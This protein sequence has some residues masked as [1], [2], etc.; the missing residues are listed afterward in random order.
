MHFVT[1]E[2]KG[3]QKIGILLQDKN[4]VIPLQEAEKFYLKSETLPATMQE[5]IEQGESAV[6]TT[7]KILSMLDDSFK[8]IA[9]AEVTI[10]APIPYPKKNI[11]CIGKNYVD[12]ALEV[13]KTKDVNLAVPKMPII[14]SKPPTSVVGTG[15]IVKQHKPFVEQI[16]YEAE[17]A[18][19]IGKTAS[20]VKK[21][22]VYD[23]V[24]G[25]SI[26]ND[27]TARDLQKN[28]VQW[29]MGKGPDTYAP[30]GPAIVHKS[31]IE[32]PHDLSIKATI[33]GDLRQNGNTKDMIF[34]IPTLIEIISA[35]ITLEPGDIIATGTPSGVGS[36]FTPPK[37]LNPGD[38]MKL[39]V[40]K[41]GFLIN[42]I[43]E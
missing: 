27:V 22:D 2:A 4:I 13:A 43:E 6:T 7:E 3:K 21:E 23:Y 28:H 19:I 16:D 35:V 30:F 31:A 42:K 32:N 10:L 20:C 12:H 25:Y 29:L 18:V 8:G 37:Y 39:E 24:F 26:I 15:A 38:E 34:D 40:E 9:L 1:F 5:L 14:F 33:S 17:L 41:I 11:F 36:G